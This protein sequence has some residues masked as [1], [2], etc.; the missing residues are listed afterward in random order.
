M[1]GAGALGKRRPPGEYAS[2]M[3]KVQ[4]TKKVLLTAGAA[5]FWL[6]VWQ[7]LSLKIND[8]IVD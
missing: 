2:A 4:P 1:P 6:L 7:A 3:S 8:L 5:L